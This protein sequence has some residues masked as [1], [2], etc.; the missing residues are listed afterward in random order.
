[1]DNIGSSLGGRQLEKGFCQFEGFFYMTTGYLEYNTLDIIEVLNITNRIFFILMRSIML[2]FIMKIG[3]A[4]LYLTVILSVIRLIII[5]KKDDSWLKRCSF[6]H[7]K[8][9]LSITIIWVFTFTFS[10]PPLLGIG[11]Y[12]QSMVGVRYANELKV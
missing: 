10:L 1:M 6:S 12:D 4:S 7:R 11:R 9:V 2:S 5:K 3:M 8:D